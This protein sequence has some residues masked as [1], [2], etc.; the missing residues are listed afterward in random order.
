MRVISDDSR[1]IEM[2]DFFFISTDAIACLKLLI[3]RELKHQCACVLI[4]STCTTL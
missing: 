2:D 4:F 3:F 1:L